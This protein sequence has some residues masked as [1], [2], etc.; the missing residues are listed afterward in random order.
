MGTDRPKNGALRLKWAEFLVAA[1]AIGSGVLWT[2]T[3]ALPRRW[4]ERYKQRKGKYRLIW[5]EIARGIKKTE[6]RMPFCR[7]TMTCHSTQ[8]GACSADQKGSNW[9]YKGGRKQRISCAS[10]RAKI[11]ACACRLD[12]RHWK[13][14]CL[15]SVLWP[16]IAPRVQTLI[17]QKCLKLIEYTRYVENQLWGLAKL[18]RAHRN[19]RSKL[20]VPAKISI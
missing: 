15:T 10:A 3:Q 20:H 1:K 14:H 5:Q 4:E 7:A 9:N 17:A 11:C 6:V 13:V 8:K 2:V 18:C 12:Q 19:R 16:K